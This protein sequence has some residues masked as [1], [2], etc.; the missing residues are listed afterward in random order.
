MSL[1]VPERAKMQLRES[2]AAA[3]R[4][5]AIIQRNGNPWTKDQQ[6]QLATIFEV[7][8]QTRDAL[9]NIV[10]ANK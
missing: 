9:Y 7:I 4:L 5:G 10:E 2:K 8:K 3:D 1:I 6:D